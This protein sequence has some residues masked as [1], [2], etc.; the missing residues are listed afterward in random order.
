MMIKSVLLSFEIIFVPRS[1]DMWCLGCLIWEVFNGS[2]SKTAQ[3]KNIG[4]VV[5]QNQ[6]PYPVWHVLLSCLSVLHTGSSFSIVCFKKRVKPGQDCGETRGGPHNI[7]WLNQ[8]DQL[9]PGGLLK[10]PEGGCWRTQR[11]VEPPPDKS[12]TDVWLKLMEHDRTPVPTQ[13]L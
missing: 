10:N 2:F 13:H 5:L 7:F 6:F 11:G 3:M 9:K 4:K 8:R 1:T 12:S